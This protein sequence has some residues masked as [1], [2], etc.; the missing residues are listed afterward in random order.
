MN[1]DVHS[2][3]ANRIKRSVLIL[4][5]FLSL[6]GCKDTS[7]DTQQ[8]TYQKRN[9][10]LAI[11]S[12]PASFRK[13]ALVSSG[14]INVETTF[15]TDGPL[16]DIHSNGFINA[17]SL[18]LDIS[19]RITASNNLDGAVVRS[20]DYSSPLDN[21][22]FIDIRALKVNEYLNTNTIDEYYLLTAD[23]KAIYRQDGTDT[24]IAN[25]D[26][27][28]SF[29]DNAWTITA[30]QATL[31]SPLVVESNLTIQATS[32]FVAGTLMVQGDL[33]ARGELNINTGTPFEKALIVDSNISVEKLVTIGRV[34]GSGSFTSYGEVNILGNAEIDGDV[35][36]YGDAKIN[37]LDNIF[38]AALYE[39]QE[40]ASE[41]GISM[42]LVHSQLFSDVKGKNSVVLFT[43]VEG[44]YILNENVINHLIENNQ[45]DDF[46][47]K[48]YLYGASIDYG[49]QLQK[50]DGL[51]PYFENKQAILNS[52][53]DAGYTGVKISESID[54]VPSNLYHTFKDENDT[55]I[56]TY[57]IYSL[58]DPFNKDNPIMLTQEERDE[59]IYNI[60]NKADIE[61]QQEEQAKEQFAAAKEEITAS[62]DYDEETKS[63]LLSEMDN[64]TAADESADKVA[65]KKEATEDRVYEWVE[66]K[67]LAVE[68]KEVEFEDIVIEG[69]SQTRG[70]FKK[71]RRKFKRFFRKVTFR[72]CKKKTEKRMISGVWSDS[73]KYKGDPWYKDISVYNNVG[74][75]TP[76]GIAMILNYHHH[77][78]K[79]K[80]H[81]Y[82]KNVS[83]IAYVSDRWSKYNPLVKKLAGRFK[84]DVNAGTAWQHYILR[85]PRETKKTM[86][87]YGMRGFSFTWHTAPWN[88][89]FQHRYISSLIR[90]NQPVMVNV[91]K[92]RVS[93]NRGAIRNHSMPVIG[94]KQQGYSG[95][96]W[97]KTLPKRRWFLVDT[98]FNSRGY[99]RFDSRS[100]YGRFGSVTYVKVY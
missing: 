56:G 4:I 52:L 3:S 46:K 55:L 63:E 36:L 93:G 100:N 88:R 5:A 47:F 95:S 23:G 35:S 26:I 84:T 99:M 73:S 77:I 34:H 76:A 54:L 53:S 61:Q 32:L 2:N 51:S 30:N 68:N 44:D 74:Y 19:G 11:E 96:C 1:M 57:Q 94:Y 59:A 85:V 41:E 14:N 10:T 78:K 25:T 72:D 80:G 67:D 20:F 75:C 90:N 43:F 66:Y 71:L 37:F 27:E 81:L 58:A 70:W 9:Q 39:A 18:S 83:N 89:S 92:A 16:A 17:R 49:A 22:G 86:S 87:E 6:A 98:E 64:S 50:F 21:K 24:E 7:T 29:E 45:I 91:Y 65:L 8:T 15:T 28:F 31:R 42:T 48:S 62:E 33:N 60:D 79:N 38:K 97:K 13:Y 82:T 12:E 40:E 69:Q